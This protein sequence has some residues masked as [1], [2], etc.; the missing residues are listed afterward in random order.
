MR[1]PTLH[2]HGGGWMEEEAIF[3]NNP[4]GK[5]PAKLEVAVSCWPELEL[6][7]DV[8]SLA[9]PHGKVGRGDNAEP[10]TPGDQGWNKSFIT[11]AG[12]LAGNREVL[13]TRFFRHFARIVIMADL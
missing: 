7:R 2:L 11:F 12:H 10:D 3:Y 5:W 9:A 8:F 6:S 4:R 13:L 1:R